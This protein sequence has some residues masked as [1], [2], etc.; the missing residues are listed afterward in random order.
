MDT[1]LCLICRDESGSQCNLLTRCNHQYHMEC[2]GLWFDSCREQKCPLCRSVI[3]DNPILEAFHSTRLSTDAFLKR[4]PVKDIVEDREAIRCAL[5]QKDLEFLRI[6]Y[7]NG[8]HLIEMAAELGQLNLVEALIKEEEVEELFNG[9]SEI[10]IEVE[11]EVDDKGKRMEEEGKKRIKLKVVE[12]MIKNNLQTISQAIELIITDRDLK[13]IKCFIDH[14][15]VTGQ[16]VMNTAIKYGNLQVIRYL[17]E[18]G[19][20]KTYK[21][22]DSVTKREGHHTGHHLEIIKT[23]IKEEEKEE[24]DNGLIRTSSN[25]FRLAVLFGN[26]DLVKELL[27]EGTSFTADAIYFALKY[28]HLEIVKCLT[29]QY[30][31]RVSNELWW[32]EA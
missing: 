20:G 16:R 27:K 26:L 12:F 32:A 23:L 6:L 5:R 14:K 18:S 8:A 7:R 11:V 1:T 24:K 2:L 4:H 19:N 9:G 30:S 21:I 10:E 29:Q 22:F 25:L 15:V 17:L 28:G 3:S 31:Q 13:M